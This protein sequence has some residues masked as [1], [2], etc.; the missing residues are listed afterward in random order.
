MQDF[1][2]KKRIP[3]RQEHPQLPCKSKLYKNLYI[4]RKKKKA[5][6]LSNKGLAFC[7]LPLRT[8]M[9]TNFV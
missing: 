7:L 3:F 4:M 8:I 9:L 1:I 5:K 6:P 2:Q